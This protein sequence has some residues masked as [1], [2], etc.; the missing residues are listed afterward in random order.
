MNLLS[1]K[2][3]LRSMQTV[4]GNVTCRACQDAASWRS[5]RQSFKDHLFSWLGWY[6]WECRKCR[7]R[8]Y[9]RRRG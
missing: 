9:H 6:P 1:P 5:E 3:N 8:F 7:S 4:Q 2:Q